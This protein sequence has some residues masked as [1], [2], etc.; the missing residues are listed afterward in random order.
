[1]SETPNN[2]LESPGEYA[3]LAADAREVMA[4]VTNPGPFP[5]CA[6]PGNKGLTF[7]KTKEMLRK[8]RDAGMPRMDRKTS[9]IAMLNTPLGAAFDAD[10]G[11]AWACVQP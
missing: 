5:S 2:T 7:E 10:G 6:A 8:C 3:K 4:R 9:L 11:R 1:M